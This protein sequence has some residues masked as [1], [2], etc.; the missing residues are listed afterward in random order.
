MNGK[1]RKKLVFC[2]ALLFILTV[3]VPLT[4]STSNSLIEEE[5]IIEINQSF[6]EPKISGIDDFISISVKEANSYMIS[7]EGAK[8]PIYCKTYELP[9]GTKITD[10]KFVSSDV[11]EITSLDRKIQKVPMIHPISNQEVTIDTPFYE[12]S[13][14]EN[15]VFPDNWYKLE[16]G[17]GINKGNEKK[18]FLTTNIYPVRYKESGDYLE[19]ISSCEISINYTV[20]QIV[21]ISSE[22]TYDLIVISPEKFEKNLTSLVN[23]KNNYGVKTKLVTIEEIYKN[24][25]GRDNAEKIKYFIK[26]AHDTWNINYVLLLGEIRILPTRQTDAYPWEGYHGNGVLTDLYYA[27]LYDENYSFCSWDANNNG[28]FGEVKYNWTWG[29]ITA[30]NIDKVDLY[31]DIHIG[32]L[33]CRNIEEVDIVVNKI[34]SYEKDTYEQNW[35]KKI[36]LAGGDTFPPSKG[37]VPFVYEGEIVN[38]KV[39]QMLPDFEH[40]F[41]WSS[42]RNLNAITFN[43]AINDGAGFLSYAGHGFEHGWGTYK[44]NALSSRIGFPQPTYLT[45]YIQFLKNEEKLPII[46]FDACLTAKL[47]YNLSDLAEYFKVFEM[48]IK[49]TGLKND[50]YNHMPCFAWCFVM[51]E[52]GGAIAAIGA[53]RPAYADV[54]S[55]GIHAGAGYI[56]WMFFDSYED[57]INLGNMLSQAQIKYLTSKGR[58]YFTIEEYM[59]LG[60]PTLKTGGYP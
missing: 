60:D 52:Q 57:G 39:S 2:A 15:D 3:F 1:I 9:W 42:K 38:E 28:T 24:F 10:V 33:A 7:P 46:F 5:H 29:G 13:D 6:S 12:I 37:S 54:D 59:L 16:K 22:E 48:L 35:F 55:S 21:H 23:H 36:I 41:L 58:D 34:I 45:P 14:D 4:S 27:D 49:I 19:Y 8:L 47:D 17:S 40:I 20:S 51:K 50:P 18:L 26:Y 31:P 30:E 44:P 56:D 32:R 43:R 53:T 11:K 25:T